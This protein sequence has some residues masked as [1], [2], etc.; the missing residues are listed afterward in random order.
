MGVIDSLER[1]SSPACFKRKDSKMDIEEIDRKAGI[2]LHELDV[3]GLNGFRGERELC[4]RRFLIGIQGYFYAEGY[5][6]CKKA[7]FEKSLLGR[8]SF[9]IRGE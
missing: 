9:I 5:D 7:T 2:L 3:I 4:V 8:L 6:D 1:G